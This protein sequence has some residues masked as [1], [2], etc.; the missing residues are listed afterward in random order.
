RSSC[1]SLGRADR[2]MSGRLPRPKCRRDRSRMRAIVFG[3]V[4]LLAACGGT[5]NLSSDAQVSH[6][7]ASAGMDSGAAD[8][9][10]P[11]D[12]GVA[13]DAGFV[14]D[15]GMLPDAGGFQTAP[16]PQFPQLVR[17]ASGVFVTPTVVSIVAANDPLANDLFRFADELIASNWWPAVAR[18][19]G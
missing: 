13:V 12:G 18:D 14:P 16:H 10:V 7:D 17:G 6:P 2:R 11:P 4:I 9:V 19:Y 8:A 15:A 3:S 5:D 1:S